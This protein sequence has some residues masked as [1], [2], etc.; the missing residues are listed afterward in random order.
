MSERTGHRFFFFAGSLYARCCRGR[1]AVRVLVIDSANTPYVSPTLDGWF[2]PFE[3]KALDGKSSQGFIELPFP[4]FYAPQAST[5]FVYDASSGD[6]RLWR[7]PVIPALR[8]AH[9]RGQRQSSIWIVLA[10]SHRRRLGLGG[11][12]RIPN[13][14]ATW[15]WGPLSRSERTSSHR[16]ARVSPLSG[17]AAASRESLP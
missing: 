5:I 17:R 9:C 15:H 7:R 2:A 3:A 13:P 12:N 10:Q 14:V 6:G 1:D 16:V 11:M 4:K 8:C